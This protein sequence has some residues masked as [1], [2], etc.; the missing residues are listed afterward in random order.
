VGP[1]VGGGGLL[2]SLLGVLWLVR[3]MRAA[4]PA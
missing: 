4:A 2:V 3:R 1:Y